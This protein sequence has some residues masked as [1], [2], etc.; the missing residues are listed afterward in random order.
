MLQFFN[1]YSLM[2]KL[3]T[4]NYKKIRSYMNTLSISSREK[5]LY[6]VNKIYEI[7]FMLMKFLWYYITKAW[8]VLSY[9]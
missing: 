3:I 7:T 8:C 1:Y 6:G 5:Y 9:L 2:N 4:N